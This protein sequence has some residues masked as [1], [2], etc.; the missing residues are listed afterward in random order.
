MAN[1]EILNGLKLALSRGE[2]LRNAMISFQNAGYPREEIE[3][4]AR[5]LQQESVNLGQ[6]PKQTQTMAP[7]KKSFFSRIFRKK[8]NNQ[9]PSG[10]FQK[11]IK[12]QE[13][14]ANINEKNKQDKIQ[15]K[16][17][18][19]GLKQQHQVQKPKQ[20][21]KQG[22]MVSNYEKPEEN[23]KR[24]FLIITLIAILV[25]LLVL[26]GVVFLFKDQLLSLFG[27]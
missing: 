3:E 17:Q 16:V 15:P 20:A 19:Q 26:L 24:K 9:M 21:K 10:R 7:E 12:Q 25:I 11:K 2:S 22:Q 27:F 1:K 6:Q 23:P 14:S 5:A 4:S 18:N 8:Q 13:S